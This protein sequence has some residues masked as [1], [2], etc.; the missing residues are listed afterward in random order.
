VYHVPD[1][2]MDQFPALC[3]YI[4]Q[5]QSKQ[6]K[7]HRNFMKVMDFIDVST[8]MYRKFIS[9]CM[10]TNLYGVL[11]TC[12]CEHVFVDVHDVF[13]ELGFHQ[14]VNMYLMM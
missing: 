3:D 5:G 8:C 4:E 14:Y 7:T 13:D 10:Y 6:L 2:H 11:N 9:T 1:G 12:L